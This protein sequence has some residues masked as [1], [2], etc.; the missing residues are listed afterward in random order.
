M[1]NN[2]LNLKIYIFD[3]IFEQYNL[4][5]FVKIV[6]NIYF[7]TNNILLTKLK[8]VNNYKYKLLLIFLNII[9]YIFNLI[10]IN[11]KNIVNLL[12]KF[13]VSI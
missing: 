13:R 4:N 3:Y 2:I 7:N 6:D 12:I 8:F 5:S 11:I 9:E 10:E 1:F